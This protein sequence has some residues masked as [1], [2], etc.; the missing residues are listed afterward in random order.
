[1][2]CLSEVERGMKSRNKS[3]TIFH[4]VSQ[5]PPF[6]NNLSN[7]SSVRLNPFLW[8]IYSKLYYQLNLGLTSE[9]PSN[10]G[11]NIF[12]SLCI[13]HFAMYTLQVIALEILMYILET[14][15]N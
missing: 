10:E 7:R 3:E 15:L 14:I 12:L 1:M 8:G 13:I 4:Y 6:M 11:R 2:F 5:T 9:V